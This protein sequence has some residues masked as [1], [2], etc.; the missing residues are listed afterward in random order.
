MIEE[1]H[2]DN[3]VEFWSVNTDGSHEQAIE[4]LWENWDLLKH[5]GDLRAYLIPERAARKAARIAALQAQLDELQGE[6]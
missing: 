3:I 2:R 4:S 6:T 5:R 1:G